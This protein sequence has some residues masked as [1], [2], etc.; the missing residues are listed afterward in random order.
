[1][2][3]ELSQRWPLPSKPRPI[4]IIG[5]GGI[6]RDAHVPAYRQAGFALGGVYDI[7]PEARE[8]AVADYGI[9]RSYSSLEEAFAG[10]YRD[11]VFD[12][13]VPGNQ[14]LGILEKAP[15]GAALLIQKPMGESLPEAREILRTCREK[16]LVAAINFQL[17]FTPN[18][19]AIRDALD[20]RLFGEITDLEVRIN[21]HTPWELWPFLRGLPRMEVL[22]HS[23]HYLD[24]IR[25]FL[26][27]PRRVYCRGVRHPQTPEL[28]DTRTSIILD[29]GDTIRCSLTMNH[30]PRFGRKHAVSRLKIEGTDGAALAKMGVNLDYPKGEPDELE[31]C[32][33]GG[34]EQPSWRTVP[35]SGSWFPEAFM[36]PMSNLQRF[37]AGED[38]VLLTSVE[39]A[40]KTMALVEACYR[41]S[42]EGGTL[43]PSYDESP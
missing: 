26:G 33:I 43:I 8:A 27:E 31:I 12:I 24:V 7:K 39:D 29:Y 34:T 3:P 1:M 11:L 40:F 21:L 32:L 20:R 15:P 9:P 14:V 28:S 22:Y 17:R 35:L 2:I 25:S 10:G 41:S 13:A 42:A 37:A 19:L 5:A 23:I 30:A 4:V 18:M 38:E 16:S 6:V 36:G